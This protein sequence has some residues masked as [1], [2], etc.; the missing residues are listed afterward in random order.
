MGI[1]LDKKSKIELTVNVNILMQ[2]LT[3]NVNNDGRRNSDNRFCNHEEKILLHRDKQQKRSCYMSKEESF[4]VLTWVY[5]ISHN[6]RPEL[7]MPQIAILIL[8]KKLP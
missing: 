4:G 2:V 8:Q 3:V 5:I 1:L 7:A 6:L